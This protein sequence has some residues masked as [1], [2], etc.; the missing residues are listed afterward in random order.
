M[1]ESNQLR[2]VL[3]SYHSFAGD[4]VVAEIELLQ[5]V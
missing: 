4:A 5:C 1:L 2:M 3:Q